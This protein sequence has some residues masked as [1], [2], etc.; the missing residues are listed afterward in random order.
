MDPDAKKMLSASLRYS[1]L[2][3]FFGV[4]VLVGY[5]IGAFLDGRLHTK[6]WFTI[7]WLL[8]GVAAGFRELFKLARQGMKDE[9]S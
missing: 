4:A 8:F 1:Y 7:T 3:V 5:A 9:Q 2:G 6:P